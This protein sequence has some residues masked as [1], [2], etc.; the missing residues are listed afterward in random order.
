MTFISYMNVT[1]GSRP[2]KLFSFIIFVQNVFQCFFKLVCK[3]CVCQNIFKGIFNL[4]LSL[5]DCKSCVYCF[6][7]WTTHFLKVNEKL[8]NA[9]II[10]CIGAQY[11]PTCFGT[12]KCHNQGIKH[13]PSEISAQHNKRRDGRNIIP[14]ITPSVTIY[15]SQPSLLPT[16]LGTFLRRIMFDSLMMAF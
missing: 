16:M 5:L 4:F 7:F 13:D 6:A 12:L 15:S 11:S 8:T 3:S 10:Q 9:L 2:K 14:T 1:A